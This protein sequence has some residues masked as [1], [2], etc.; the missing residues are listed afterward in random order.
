MHRHSS[1]TKGR[2]R[3]GVRW[4]AKMALSAVTL[5]PRRGLPMV[6]SGG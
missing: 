1:G 3:G 6:V 4:L 2:R 5:H